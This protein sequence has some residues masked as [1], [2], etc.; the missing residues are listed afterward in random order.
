M[1]E[2]STKKSNIGIKILYDRIYKSI[3]QKNYILSSLF[4]VLKYKFIWRIKEVYLPV[5]FLEGNANKKSGKMRALFL[6][7]EVSLKYISKK[8]FVDKP[9]IT[10]IQNISIFRVG[11]VLKKYEDK[12]D[13]VVVK[14]DLFF[15]RFIRKKGFLISPA[16][17]SMRLDISESLDDIVKKFKKSAKEDLRKIKNY[18]FTYEITR[19]K[20]KFDYF[21]Y[22]IRKQ[23]F[24][25]R[26]G[27]ES[28]A[29][30]KSYHEIKTSFE[31][32]LLLL[33]KQNEKYVA[34]FVVHANRRFASPHFMGIIEKP[35]M[36][37]G[38]GSAL[39]YYL[40]EWSK[41]EGLVY[42]DYGNTRAFLDEGAFRFKRKWGMT[43]NA[44]GGLKGIFAFS[45]KNEKNT[46]VYDFFERNPLMYLEGDDLK[47]LIF[48]KEKPTFEK[49]NEVYK[50]Y[51]TP[52]MKEINVIYSQNSLFNITKGGFVKDVVTV[53][54]DINDFKKENSQIAE[55]EGGIYRK[56]S[57]EHKK[58]FKDLLNKYPNQ[59][60][61]IFTTFKNSFSRLR[62]DD[63]NLKR[64]NEKNL[65]DIFDL[66]DNKKISK[67][68]I[69]PILCCLV[70]NNSFDVQDA[71]KDLELDNK[72]DFSTEEIIKRIVIKREKIIK[73]NGF[74]CFNTIMGEIMKE[75]KG[76]VD[77]K[78]ISKLL[79]VELNKILE[80]N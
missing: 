69:Y 79:R 20:K 26:I 52:N 12:V 10:K 76:K 43:A 13:F 64:F 70:K 54:S 72:Q 30:A 2:K 65:F 77:G 55:E 21:F 58:I 63:I 14:T 11:K 80:D 5:F 51:F 40:I 6:G 29:G 50:K 53:H 66:L 57:A 59:R 74:E 22:D 48:L 56:L 67:E 28:L 62:N 18:N 44:P 42:L 24:S 33:V 45:I 15:S 19:D 47:G 27:D 39:N 7:H 17:I 36:K 31:N 32:G 75:L 49:I 38:A 61:V 1:K 3:I 34:G 46:A 60:R 4:L 16:W 9:T 23:Y 25:N 78:T 68:A 37:Q 41:K 8:I 71:V 73:T 35:Y